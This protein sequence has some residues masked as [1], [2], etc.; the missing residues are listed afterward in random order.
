MTELKINEDNKMSDTNKKIEEKKK[1]MTE[2]AKE[3]RATEQHYWKKMG[4]L[5]ILQK[6]LDKLEKKDEK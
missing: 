4:A 6:D 3:I 5:E 2:I 1:E